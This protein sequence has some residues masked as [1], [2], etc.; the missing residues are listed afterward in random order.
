[1]LTFLIPAYNEEKRIGRCISV[2]VSEFPGSKYLII[3]DGNDRTPE[4]V[5]RFSQVKL[6]KFGKRVGK[7]RAIIEGIK[8][9][10][11]NDIVAI[12]DADL[13]V[14]ILDIHKAENALV[15][16]DMLIAKRIYSQVPKSRLFL[17]DSYIALAKLFFSKLRPLPDWQGGF[18]L[19]K[20][21][22]VSMVSQELILN[23]FIF[24]TNL[25]YSFLRHNMN[26]VVFPIKW[27]HEEKDSKV[28]GQIFKVL[29][30]DLLSLI[31]MRAYYFPIKNWL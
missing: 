7:G 27:I 9:V 24:D 28:S 12:V 15:N 1:M 26:V 31:K 25:V 6:I 5:S 21:S 3:F 29:L 13:P 4:V 11:Q 18:K 17:H 23:D 22:S 14:D 30:L 19:V 2:L 10:D 16:G 20:A 8:A